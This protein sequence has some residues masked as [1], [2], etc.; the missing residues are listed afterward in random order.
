MIAKMSQWM[1]EHH[2]RHL[3]FYTPIHWHKVNGY[4]HGGTV[5][6]ASN[7]L[8]ETPFNSTWCAMMLCLWQNMGRWL[9][10]RQDQS[11]TVCCK[12]LVLA[13]GIMLNWVKDVR[14][15][16]EL[17]FW[18]RGVVLGKFVKF[19]KLV[20]D[21]IVIHYYITCSVLIFVKHRNSWP[22]RSPVAMTS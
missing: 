2:S 22:G 5:L 4:A 17:H 20:L 14:G 16:N 15:M 8:T 11:F 3:F 9:C 21:I 7:V 6:Y 18:M 1:R 13:C 10:M 19:P 12:V